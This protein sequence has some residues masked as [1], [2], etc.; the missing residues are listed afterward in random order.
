M[1]PLAPLPTRPPRRRRTDPAMG[2]LAAGVGC[3]LLIGL[4]TMAVGYRRAGQALMHERERAALLDQRIEQLEAHNRRLI[5]SLADHSDTITR[6]YA[7][8]I[9]R[10][11]AQ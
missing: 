4:L 7:D 1:A 2:I 9:L 6:L 3:A 5:E 11:G 10:A 8:G